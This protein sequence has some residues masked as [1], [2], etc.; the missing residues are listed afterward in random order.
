MAKNRQGKRQCDK[1]GMNKPRQYKHHEK[2]LY[3]YNARQGTCDSLGVSNARV[4]DGEASAC[5][6]ELGWSEFE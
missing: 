6:G 5:C 1:Y 2:E 3:T 4:V